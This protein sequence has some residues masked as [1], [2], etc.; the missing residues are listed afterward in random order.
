M[1]LI[2]AKIKSVFLILYLLWIQ[3]T[4]FWFWPHLFHFTVG[5]RLKWKHKSWERAEWSE[6]CSNALIIKQ[7]IID[8]FSNLPSPNVYVLPETCA[9]LMSN[10]VQG[11]FDFVPNHWPLHWRQSFIDLKQ[12]ELY[13]TV[14][15]LPSFLSSCH[16]NIIHFQQCNGR[17]D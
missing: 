9:K 2:T 5:V 15:R 17:T 4:V 14:N 1:G 16:T 8:L 13:H 7:K 10:K 6:Y 3:W 12:I 11:E